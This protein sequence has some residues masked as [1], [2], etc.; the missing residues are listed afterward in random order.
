MKAL[1][2]QINPHF[3][4]NALSLINWKAIGAGEEDISK[5]TLLLSDFYRTTLNKGESIIT[6][7][8]EIKNI[9]SYIE[10][11]LIMHDYD[12]E[13]EYQIDVGSME[14]L[15]P[16]LILQ[17]LVENALEH[18]L[19]LKEEGEKKLVLSCQETSE[20]IVLAVLDTGV[21]MDAMTTNS[22]VNTHMTGYGVHNVNDRLMLF[23]GE[24]YK[25]H[26]VSYPG[27]GT[28]V[29]IHIP[30]KLEIQKNEEHE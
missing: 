20:D 1:Q 13:V 5:I 17:P 25:L 10:I 26:I 7:E 23:Y 2:A 8:G 16:K 12:F 21:G 4:Y 19:D 18:G 14:Y 22:L 28:K 29:E 9:K 30:K 6:I 11:Q 27:V 15:M 24:N 3:L